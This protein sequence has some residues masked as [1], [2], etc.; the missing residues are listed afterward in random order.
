MPP[1][2]P[3]T[4][5]LL[6]KTA[7]DNG[8]DNEVGTFDG[9]VLFSTSRAP[10]RA[11]FRAPA[12]N[13]LVAAFSKASV[14]RE[15][16]REFP[17]HAVGSDTALPVGAAG[18]FVASGFGDLHPIVRRSFQL[19]NAL[20]NEL[21]HVFENETQGMPKSTEAE[22]LVVQRVGQDLF[23]K[24]LLDFWDGRCAVTGLAEPGLLRASHIKA[25]AS[26]D[27]DEERL[28]VFNG[29][30]LAAHLDAAF[31]GGYVIVANDGAVVPTKKL[32]AESAGLLGIHPNMRVHSLTNEHR[33]YLE[34]HRKR[35]D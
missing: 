17:D 35:W 25:W 7:R 13:V 14:V 22:R 28:D 31:D 15:L 8:F 5:F 30:L 23:R 34:W 1:P 24:G 21:L 9:W 26:C 11:W 4:S 10:L 32:S 16:K 3:Y 6:E 12:E 20:P 33:K 18:A 2:N 29:L 19:A 27:T